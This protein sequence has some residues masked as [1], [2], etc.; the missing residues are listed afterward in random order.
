MIWGIALTVMSL[1]SESW[2]S[3]TATFKPSP[4]AEVAI[5]TMPATSLGWRFFGSA[6]PV[7]QFQ[8][9]QCT[10]SAARASSAASNF[11]QLM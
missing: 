11:F 5:F 4:I 10:P 8:S 3:I 9:I 1:P 7:R 6:S 2:A